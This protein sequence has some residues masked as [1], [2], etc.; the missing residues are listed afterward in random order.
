MD[1][2]II[3]VLAVVAGVD[4]WSDIVQFAEDRLD[5]FKTF[6]ELPAG[7]ICRLGCG[8]VTG[9]LYELGQILVGNA[10]GQLVAI[11]GKR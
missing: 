1:I 4:G 8:K 6:L 7:C 5:W 10:D 11:D 2:V 9:V 3:S